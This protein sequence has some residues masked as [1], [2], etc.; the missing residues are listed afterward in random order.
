MSTV[1]RGDQILRTTTL[2]RDRP[3]REQEQRNLQGESDGSSSNPVRGPSWRDGEAKIDT[4]KCITNSVTVTNYARRFLLGRWSFLGPGSE[5]KWCGT[6][7][8]EPDGD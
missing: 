6:Y 8:D 1:R 5:K 2:I 4:E 3:D 7:S